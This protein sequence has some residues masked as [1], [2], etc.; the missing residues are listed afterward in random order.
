MADVTTDVSLKKY[1]KV[2]FAGMIFAGLLATAGIGWGI[3]L[4]LPVL[5]AEGLSVADTVWLMG[6][7]K[8]SPNNGA[9]LLPPIDLA[10]MD[11][12][13]HPD[14]KQDPK[15]QALV[16]DVRAAFSTLV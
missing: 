2:I 11:L 13:W 5:L 1:D 15:F 16:A 12:C 4:L 6:K 14:I 10:A 7:D 8:T 3:T 9:M